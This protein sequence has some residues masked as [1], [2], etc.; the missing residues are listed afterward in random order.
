MSLLFLGRGSECFSLPEPRR[1]TRLA[2][3]AV[4]LEEMKSSSCPRSPAFLMKSTV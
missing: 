2:S 4:T 1:L 3:A